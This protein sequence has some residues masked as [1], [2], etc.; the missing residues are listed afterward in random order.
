[1]KN[2]FQDQIQALQAQA[3]DLGYDLTRGASPQVFLEARAQAELDSRP[4]AV[5]R[6]GVFRRVRTRSLLTALRARPSL[7]LC[8]GPS[9]PRRGSSPR[10]QEVRA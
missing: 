7:R 3:R 1:M 8:P 10:P 9:I 5:P 4:K 2:D 6:P